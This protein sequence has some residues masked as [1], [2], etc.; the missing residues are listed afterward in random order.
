MTDIEIASAALLLIGDRPITSFNESTDRALACK[1]FYNDTRDET[2]RSHRW[3]FAKRRTTLAP[4]SETP[5]F[6]WTYKYALPTDPYCLR[7][8]QLEDIEDEFTVEGRYMYAEVSSANIIYIA[9]I[10]D[11]QTFDALFTTALQYRLAHKL[12]RVLTSKAGLSTEMYQL[13]KLS[14]QEARGISA[15][16][17]TPETISCDDLDEVR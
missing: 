5:T 16:E 14:L 7:V 12:A 2:L 3:N 13:F 17:G 9:R 1:T 15:Q 6:G 11:S 8:L 10:T 4:L